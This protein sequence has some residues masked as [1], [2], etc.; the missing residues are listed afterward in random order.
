MTND[1]NIKKERTNEIVPAFENTIF[2]DEIKDSITDMAEAGLDYFTDFNPLLESM[3]IV[4]VIYG[5]GKTVLNIRERN[6]L[7]QTAESMEGFYV[8]DVDKE[9][10]KVYK[11]TLRKNPKKEDEELIRIIILLDRYYEK[12]KAHILGFLF[13]KYIE[14][15]IDWEDFCEYADLIT[16]L[17]VRDIDYL[18]KVFENSDLDA[19]ENNE[20]IYVRLQ[21]LGLVKISEGWKKQGIS[22]SFINGTHVEITDYGKRFSKLIIEETGK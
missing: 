8:Q 19:E 16:D 7:K 13:K 22:T 1:Q 11:E 15:K 4:K 12:R 18:L 5:L 10:L 3:P 21:W 2:N 9:K 17:Y 14:G 20:H 6:F